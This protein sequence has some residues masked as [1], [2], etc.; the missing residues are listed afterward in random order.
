MTAGKREGGIAG[1]GLTLETRVCPC[2]KLNWLFT[3]T[4][5]GQAVTGIP[6]LKFCPK[7]ALSNQELWE[8]SGVPP[9]I[10]NYEINRHFSKDNFGQ[11]MTF[12][13]K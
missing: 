8:K 1:P 5:C 12:F 6:A 7:K 4:W 2:G 10:F 13:G 3:A 9:W 11:K